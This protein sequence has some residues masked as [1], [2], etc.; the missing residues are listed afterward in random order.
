MGN[1]RA[2]APRRVNISQAAATLAVVLHLPPA[3]FFYLSQPTRDQY[4]SWELKSA[5]T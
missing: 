2:L 1:N 4:T 5:I 3:P